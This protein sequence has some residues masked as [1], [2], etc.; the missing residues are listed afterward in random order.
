LRRTKTTN[1]ISKI[2][3]TILLTVLETLV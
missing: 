1:R 2:T 3:F